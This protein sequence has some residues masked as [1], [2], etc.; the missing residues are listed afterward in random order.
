MT[1]QNTDPAAGDHEDCSRM[2]CQL[3]FLFCFFLLSS[4]NLEH[5]SEILFVFRYNRTPFPL[6]WSIT[7]HSLIIIEVLAISCENLVSFYQAV[8][9]HTSKD[10]WL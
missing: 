2:L 6:L 7:H 9:R 4:R 1:E 10:R 5:L 8:S 3:Y